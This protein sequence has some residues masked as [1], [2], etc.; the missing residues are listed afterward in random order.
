MAGDRMA[1]RGEGAGQILAFD[2][3]KR[4]RLRPS[5]RSRKKCAGASIIRSSSRRSACSFLGAGWRGFHHPASLCI[6]AYGFLIS[7]RETIPPSERRSSACLQ[8]FPK[9]IDPRI[10]RSGPRVTSETRSRPWAEA[11]AIV[12]R[13]SRCPCCA[14][15]I[16]HRKVHGT[17]DAVRLDRDGP[18]RRIACGAISSDH[19]ENTKTFRICATSKCV[20]KCQH[21]E[22]FDFLLWCVM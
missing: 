21:I 11:A 18:D 14:R 2:T 12:L 8:A 1:Q 20:A 3:A 16:N 5:G 13:L 10:G 17:C 6:A 9:T 7:E 15:T 4:F 19:A 22:I